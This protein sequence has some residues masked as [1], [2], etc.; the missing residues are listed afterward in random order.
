[1][2]ECRRAFGIEYDELHRLA[3]EVEADVALFDPDDEAFLAPDDMPAQ[4][5]AACR[6]SGQRAPQTPGEVVRSILLS[7]ACKYRLVLERL[8]RVTG[9]RVEVV[10]VIGGGVRNG[11]LCRLTADLTGLPLLAGPVE[12]TAL[13]NVLVQA[14]ATGEIGSLDEL[15]AIAAASTDPIPFEPSDRRQD[16]DAVYGRFL[17]VTGLAVDEPEPA[18]A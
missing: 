14:R 4:V 12:A 8:V 2:Q 16:A 3:E 13:G 7:L 18:I 1:V 6:A 11:L 17:E 15:R 10:H 5:A 9:R